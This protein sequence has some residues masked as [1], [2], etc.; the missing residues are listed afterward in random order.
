MSRISDVMSWLESRA[1]VK[2]LGGGNL[3]S[4]YVS[5]DRVSPMELVTY[6][7]LSMPWQDTEICSRWAARSVMVLAPDCLLWSDEAERIVAR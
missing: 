7:R 6:G 1:L 3:H 4:G 5:I 2:I